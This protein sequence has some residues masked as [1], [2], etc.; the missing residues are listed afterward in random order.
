MVVGMN[1]GDP[2]KKITTILINGKRVSVFL[3]NYTIPYNEIY[4]RVAYQLRSVM[5]LR[6]Q[7]DERIQKKGKKLG[8]VCPQSICVIFTQQ[9]IST[10]FLT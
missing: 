8:V 9:K 1:H 7:N 3:V 4:V 2:M 5:R 10:S 6:Y